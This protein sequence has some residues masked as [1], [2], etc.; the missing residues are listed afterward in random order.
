MS[1]PVPQPSLDK[2]THL[3]EMGYNQPTLQERLDKYYQD[4]TK[5]NT[6]GEIIGRAL[7]AEMARSVLGITSSGGELIGV[8]SELATTGTPSATTA[9]FGD[10]AW[11]EITLADTTIEPLDIEGVTSIGEALMV[12]ASQ[13][14]G[15]GAI[16]AA[17]QVQ[18]DAVSVVANAAQ[19][20]A[21]NA[22]TSTEF[23]AL[24]N[25]VDALDTRVDT[26][27]TGGGSSGGGKQIFTWDAG[28]Q[29]YKDS[30]TLSSTYD[31]AKYSHE[32]QRGPDPR[33][34]GYTPAIDRDYWLKP[35]NPNPGTGA[36]NQAAVGLTTWPIASI[37]GVRGTTELVMYTYKAD[38]IVSPA[39]QYGV[40]VVF[41]TITKVPTALYNRFTNTKYTATTQSAFTGQT[42][43]LSSEFVLSGHGNIDQ[44]GYAGMWLWTNFTKLVSGNTRVD[45]AKIVTLNTV[46]TPGGGPVDPPPAP[47]GT[48]LSGQSDTITTK[49]GS[50]ATWRGR[51]VEIGGNWGP[52]VNSLMAEGPSYEIT[53]GGSGAYA[54]VPAIDYAI[55]AF[56]TGTTWSQAASGTMDT[57]WTQ[58]VLALKSAWG[59]RAASKCFIR[60]AHE[61]NGNWYPWKVAP[62]DV[63]NYINGFRR[64]AN[65]IRNNFP[66]A[67][68][69]WCM[70]AGS[71]YSYDIRSL[72]PGDAYVDV[73]ATDDYN[74][75]PFVSTKAAFDAQIISDS[76]T[77]GTLGI[78]TVRQLALSHGKPFALSE[79]SNSGVDNGGGGGESPVFMT[80]TYNWLSAHGGTGAGNALYE[81]LFNVPGYGDHYSIYPESLETGNTTTAAEYKR[82]WSSGLSVPPTDPPPTPGTLPA[83]VSSM[84]FHRWGS[85]GIGNYPANVKDNLDLIVLGLAQSGG[86]GT[87]NLSYQPNYPGST[88]AG[89]AADIRAMIARGINVIMGFGGSSDGGI[90]ITNSAQVDQAFNSF[91]SFRT[92]YGITGIDIDLEPSGSSWNQTSLVSLCTRLKTAFGSGFI[93]GVTP[94]L[95]APY[96]ARWMALAQALMAA[97]A[98]DYMAPMLYDFPE[99]NVGGTGSGSL[100]AVAKQKCDQMAGAGIPANKMILGFM[101]KPPAETY[102]NATDSVAKLTT[103]YNYVKGFYPTLRGAFHWEDKIQQARSWDGLLGLSPYIHS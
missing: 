68:I 17:S 55:G 46:T 31:T 94:G 102:P 12:A 92:T 76:T 3:G 19:T 11:K 61:F 87:G 71:S 45:P 54:N 65:I 58:T 8:P 86:A 62:A 67:Q 4:M 43:I 60:I 20:T 30:I 6:V 70:N 33:L 1:T 29:L 66:G 72:Y 81:T 100:A 80:E 7:D 38:Q 14:N 78:E 97:N 77:G 96:D 40:E 37:D 84:W 34:K 75:D 89:H 39:N 52:E 98:F 50:F 24:S 15:R 74:R 73:I 47:T 53:Q 28:N 99:A 49:N 103:A 56:G 101:M 90:T 57:V 26:I 51:S 36:P 95:Y 32:W 59:T 69:V 18:V 42:P 25:S 9:L 27:E 16:G 83:K 23:D 21:N 44:P 35:A 64:F 91:S 10:G 93:I 82:L 13:G 88:V 63:T 48:W 79:W 85:G 5:L 41:D 22:A 2:F